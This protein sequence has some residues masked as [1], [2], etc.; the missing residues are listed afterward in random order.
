M[1]LTQSSDKTIS[2]QAR[3]AYTPSSRESQRTKC[4]PEGDQEKCGIHVLES[5]HARHTM[6]WPKMTPTRRVHVPRNAYR[7]FTFFGGFEDRNVRRPLPFWNLEYFICS[8]NAGHLADPS[9]YRATGTL[10]PWLLKPISNTFFSLYE[11]IALLKYSIVFTWAS[12]HASWK[13]MKRQSRW[14]I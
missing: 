7:P 13:R 14:D 3:L 10:L 12:R 11:H 8:C 9:T 2:K 1:N 5:N 6:M 4:V